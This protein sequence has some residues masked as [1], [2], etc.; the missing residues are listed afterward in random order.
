[1]LSDAWSSDRGPCL[2]WLLPQGEATLLPGRRMVSHPSAR[3]RTQAC[4]VCEVPGAVE[5]L[6]MTMAVGIRDDNG[7]LC[8]GP[9]RISRRGATLTPADL[10]A[11][12]LDPYCAYGPSDAGVGL[13]GASPPRQSVEKMWVGD[14]SL[15]QG[16]FHGSETDGLVMDLEC[17]EI[18]DEE[19]VVDVRRGSGL[20]VR[21]SN[22]V[23]GMRAC[24]AHLV[25]ADMT[26]WRRNYVCKDIEYDEGTRRGPEGGRGPEGLAVD[27]SGWGSSVAILR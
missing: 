5:G 7:T 19:D 2:M 1:M 21:S 8:G 13:T 24:A 20:Q 18:L 16:V 27:S 3:A 11:S 26:R 6:E 17:E 4:S 14:E 15:G 25:A 12:S 9:G 22:D 10:V 23:R